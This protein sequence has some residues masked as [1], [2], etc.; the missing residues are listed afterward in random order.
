GLTILCIILLILTPFAF[1]NR[2]YLGIFITA[3]IYSIYAASWDFLT[4]FLGQASFG[5][6]IFWG[7]AGYGYAFFVYYM[8]FPWWIALIIGPLIAVLFGVLIGAPV[9][10]LKGPYL[11]LATLAFSLILFT[12]FSMGNLKDIFWGSEGISGYPPISSNISIIYY[13]ILG[14]FIICF[15]LMIAIGRSN[16]GTIFKSIRDDD[17]GAKASGINLT[18][19]KIIG[20][21]ISALF[22]GVAGSLM[23]LYNRGVNPSGA[24]GSLQS[25]YAIIMASIGGVGTITGSALGAFL[26]ICL[27]E[28]LRDFAQYALLIFSIIFILIVRFADEGILKPVVENLKDLWDLV[29]G[30]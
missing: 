11:A 4:G 19:Y 10:R 24:Y 30:K 23:A 6:S 3:M 14:L 16:L 7:V 28:L 17:I 13:I 25:F 1:T 22:A 26:F 20:F 21:M 9:L 12:L 29:V 2:Y 15:I 8:S 27:G 5:H 18:K